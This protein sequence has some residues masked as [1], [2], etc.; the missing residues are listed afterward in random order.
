[1][2]LKMVKMVYFMCI[3]YN[4]KLGEKLASNADWECMTEQFSSWRISAFKYSCSRKPLS[5]N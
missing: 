3:Y 4:L 1:M 5:S 2:H